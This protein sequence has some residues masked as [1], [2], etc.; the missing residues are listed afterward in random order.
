MK[1]GT[2]IAAI[3]AAVGGIYTGFW[4]YSAQRL[5][6]GIHEVSAAGPAFFLKH[7]GISCQGFPFKVEA[8][9]KNP[10]LGTKN[11]TALKHISTEG[12]WTVGTTVFQRSYW[13]EIQGKTRLELSRG[14]SWTLA[15]HLRAEIPSSKKPLGISKL[16]SESPVELLKLVTQAEGSFCAKNLSLTCETEKQPLFEVDSWLF[17]CKKIKAA[18]GYS[19]GRQMNVD[20]QG[21]QVDQK[22]LA[23]LIYQQPELMPMLAQYQPRGKNNLSGQMRFQCCLEEKASPFCFELEKMNFQ[24]ALGDRG[25]AQGKFEINPIQSSDYSGIFTLRVMQEI[26]SKAH[27]YMLSDLRSLFQQWHMMGY[28]ASNPEWGNLFVDHWDQVSALIPDYSS[29]GPIEMQIDL[30]FQVREK[31]LPEEEW[32]I[33]LKNCLFKS[34]AHEIVLKGS[35][36][37]ADPGA[38]SFLELQIPRYHQF[39][40]DLGDYYNRWQ[41]VL[42]ATQTVSEREMT[43]M[44]V[45]AVDRI[46]SFLELF[47]QPKG[48]DLC[49]LVEG[50][51]EGDIRVGSLNT[52]VLASEFQK[53]MVDL[54]EEISPMSEPHIR[55]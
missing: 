51:N 54:A 53:L 52:E 1:K 20:V 13:S 14:S 26:S 45:K 31:G 43:P 35:K 37:F 49:I 29:W 3:V 8:V 34:A 41:A 23:R 48:K 4:F 2:I 50:S 11:S 47:S 40:Q 6:K 32:K 33:D 44:T 24:G 16:P 46:A 39:L 55:I 19:T 10:L 17:T 18:P 36:N 12:T 21:Y 27:A 38:L 28:F 5:K 22:A 9:I 7:E 30:G 25:S 42:T 15:G